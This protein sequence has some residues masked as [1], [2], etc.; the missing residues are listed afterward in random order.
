MRNKSDYVFVLAT[1]FGLG[2]LL[3]NFAYSNKD[4]AD[5]SLHR[6]AGLILHSSFTAIEDT[7]K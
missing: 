5:T 6:P 2:V 1:L 4:T 3:S 7:K